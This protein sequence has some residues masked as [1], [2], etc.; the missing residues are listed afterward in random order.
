[1]K[2]FVLRVDSVPLPPRFFSEELPGEVAVA[3]GAA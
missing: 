1:M 2:S 3:A